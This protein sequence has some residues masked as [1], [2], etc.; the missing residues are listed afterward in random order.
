MSRFVSF[1][2]PSLFG[3]GLTLPQALSYSRT[4][5]LGALPR[6]GTSSYLNSLVNNK[7]PYITNQVKDGFVA[8]LNSNKAVAAQVKLFKMANVQAL[9]CVCLSRDGCDP[10]IRDNEYKLYESEVQ[11]GA[12]EKRRRP[13]SRLRPHTH[14]YPHAPTHQPKKFL[15]NH[16]MQALWF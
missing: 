5:G 11:A 12:P 14:V 10:E 15:Y 3:T 6:E 1:S 7:F 4:D 9:I 2:S 16:S 13:Y 8:S